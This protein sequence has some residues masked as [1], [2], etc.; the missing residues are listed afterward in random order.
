[1]NNGMKK[2]DMK[3]ILVADDEKNIRD[4]IKAYLE[5]EGYMVLTAEDGSKAMEIFNNH[6]ID[7]R[8]LNK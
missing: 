5:K 2:S 8:Y 4:I 7:S 3:I 1:M 6:N